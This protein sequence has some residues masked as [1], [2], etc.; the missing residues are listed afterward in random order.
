MGVSPNFDL[1]PCSVVW[2]PTGANCEL[3]PTFGA[4]KFH[5]E[6]KD[7]DIFEDEQGLTPVDSVTTGA[8]CELTI[9]MTRTTLHKLQ[10]VFHRA[11][12][13]AD[14]IYVSNPVGESKFASSKLML[15]KPIVNGV[16]S[17]LTKEWL[18]ILRAS[19]KVNLDQVYDNSTQRIVNVVFKGYPDTVTGQIGLMWRYGL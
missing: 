14:H 4:V 7:A 11:A 15:V 10:Y 16:V 6:E 3:N 19:P 2:D 9:P 5:W 8:V 17:V 1:G 12:Y 18:Y 13:A